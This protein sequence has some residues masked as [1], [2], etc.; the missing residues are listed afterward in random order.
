M[1][2]ILI[3]ILMIMILCS[4]TQ[5]QAE[6]VRSQVTGYGS[7]AANADRD[8]ARSARRVSGGKGYA[9]VSRKLLKMKDGTWVKIKVI[10]YDNKTTGR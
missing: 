6:R 1:K 8:S 3:K 9:V 10:E 7:N 4:V 5:A 2:K